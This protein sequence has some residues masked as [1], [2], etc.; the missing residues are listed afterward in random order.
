ML[1]SALGTRNNIYSRKSTWIFCSGN[2]CH[3][4][5]RYS[6]ARCAGTERREIEFQ[7][8]VILAATFA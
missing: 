5:N 4:G 3:V 1:I 6:A 8:I 7:N 2:G